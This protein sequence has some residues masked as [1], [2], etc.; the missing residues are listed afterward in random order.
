MDER[1]HA[2]G[3]ATA[4]AEDADAPTSRTVESAQE[5]RPCEPSPE[6]RPAVTQARH[7]VWP[8]AAGGGAG[9]VAAPVVI[10]A[11]PTAAQ[12]PPPDIVSQPK[13]EVGAPGTPTEATLV[14][15]EQAGEQPPIV[16]AAEAR[17]ATITLLREP[18]PPVARVEAAPAPP[19]ALADLEQ[20]AIESP[21]V[22]PPP[23]SW[24]E[25]VA[26]TTPPP[27][28]V[29]LPAASGARRYLR[30]A[31]RVTAVLLPALAVLVL[32]LVVLY[33]WIDP[34]VS[35]LILGQRLTGTPIRQRWVPLER[36]SP[37]LQLA[38]VM[39]EDARFC[40]HNGVDWGELKEAIEQAL[41]GTPRGGSTITMQVVKN[42]FLWPSK[43]YLRKALE[44]PLAYLIEAAWPKRRILEIYLNI[45]EWG[46]GIFGAEAAARYHFHKPALLLG[47]R[48][49]AL[50]AVSLP[51][52]SER[53]AGSPGP[54]T[55]R[56][57]D[58]LL[59]RMRA[60]QGNAACVRVK[61]AQNG[62]AAGLRIV[63]GQGRRQPL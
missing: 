54:G 42:L 40:R 20:P 38:V 5:G 13:P 47:P 33:R 4:D 49:A 41:D 15:V 16:R 19:A 6:P 37:S 55:L 24:H 1:A 26:G 48:E 29:P 31:F 44:I 51:N 30:L 39:S 63:S 10:T 50:L 43:S 11:E 9:A 14:R 46:P 2:R 23:V 8:R 36:M 52:P 25:R 3:P 61:A 45:A 18:L 35:T 56:L 17:Q 53:E 28:A 57:A 21:I 58:N 7:E 27:R 62:P 34:P 32:T 59:V 22:A 60:A 12:Q